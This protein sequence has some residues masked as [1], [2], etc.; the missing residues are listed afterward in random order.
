MAG[1][2]DERDPGE[3]QVKEGVIARKLQHRSYLVKLTNVST[4]KSCG[5]QEIQQTSSRTDSR[6]QLLQQ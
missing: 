6:L 3:A 2:D 1:D 5:H 4:E